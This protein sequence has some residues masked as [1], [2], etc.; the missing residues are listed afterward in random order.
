MCMLEMTQLQRQCVR[1]SAPLAATVFLILLLSTISEAAREVCT[2]SPANH[3]LSGTS[4]WHAI[5][6]S[7]DM[8]E[9]QGHVSFMLAQIH[10]DCRAIANTA[11]RYRFGKVHV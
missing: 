1:I 7:F 10:V 4:V 6:I 5:Y 2:L 8:H 11:A 9:L 3:A